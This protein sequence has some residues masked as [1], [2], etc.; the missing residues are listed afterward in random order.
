M[1]PRVYLVITQTHFYNCPL[2]V[3]L[4]LKSRTS[5]GF[6]FFI[7][8]MALES[9]ATWDSEVG[10]ESEDYR[11]IVIKRCVIWGGASFTS[12]TS[13][14]YLL[15]VKLILSLRV[16]MG[17]TWSNTHKALRSVSS[18]WDELPQNA[19]CCSSPLSG[20]PWQCHHR[21]PSDGSLLRTQTVNQS[22]FWRSG[23][24]ETATS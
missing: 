4:D 8:Q 13:F 6:T 9:P 10:Q 19:S 16:T 3:T 1:W 17:I 21:K 14:L 11:D 12:V 7:Y 20:E 15:N 24:T 23:D 18:V 2:H 5:L 22:G